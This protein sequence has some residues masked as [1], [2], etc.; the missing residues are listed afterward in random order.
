MCQLSYMHLTT[1]LESDHC[2]EGTTKSWNG[3]HALSFMHCAGGKGTYCYY[4]YMYPLQY[5]FVTSMVY[6]AY[7]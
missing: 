1:N 5:V 4:H 7:S 6:G 2:N 3:A